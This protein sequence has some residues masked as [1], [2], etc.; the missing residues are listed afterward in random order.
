MSDEGSTYAYYVWD[1]KAKG[2]G[3]HMYVDAVRLS[4]TSQNKFW[5]N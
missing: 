5:R 1:N 2:N 3:S 4:E